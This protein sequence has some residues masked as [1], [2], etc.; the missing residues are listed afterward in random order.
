MHI[1]SF[2]IGNFSKLEHL[3][4]Q[5]FTRHGHEFHLWMY[6]APSIAL[7]KK[8]VIR[9]ANEI[10]PRERI[11]R[12]KGLGD[13]RKD[14]LGGFSD[15]FRYYLLYKQGGWYVDMDVTCLESFDSLNQPYVFRKHKTCGTVANIIKCPKESPF[16][17]PLIAE[18]EE[19]ITEDNSNWVLPLEIFNDHIIK[20]D[21]T[22][23][24][25]DNKYFGDDSYEKLKLIK[26]GIYFLIKD[27]LPQKAIHWCREA[28]YG[29]WDY[30]M[31]YNW[32]SPPPLTPYYNL[33]CEYKLLSKPE[34]S[35]TL[36]TLHF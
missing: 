15:L 11:F 28:S 3:T 23:Y 8:V 22:Q 10:L 20:N 26:Y 12:Y 29:R 18:T 6:D 7:P 21:L 31:R 36:K 4:L 13:C 14:S 32:D 1:N 30:T 5:S 19:K 34:E 17:L 2:W 35:L 24:I 33:L 25:I 27:T 16:L 9:D